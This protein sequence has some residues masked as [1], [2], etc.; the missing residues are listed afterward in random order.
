MDLVTD[1][2]P[3]S[4]GIIIS[5]PRSNSDINDESYWMNNRGIYRSDNCEYVSQGRTS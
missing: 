5:M 2:M 3:N 4:K 1:G